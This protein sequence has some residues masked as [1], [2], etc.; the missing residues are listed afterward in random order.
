VLLRVDQIIEW[1][2]SEGS[3][4]IMKIGEIMV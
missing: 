3:P 4:G 2:M 1:I